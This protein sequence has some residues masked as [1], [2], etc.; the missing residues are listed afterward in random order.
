MREKWDLLF[1]S[2]EDYVALLIGQQLQLLIYEAHVENSE[3]LQEKLTLIVD[4]PGSKSA[5]AKVDIPKRSIC[6]VPVGPNVTC[7]SKKVPSNML[8]L[9]DVTPFHG[10]SLN[11]FCSPN[12]KK[13]QEDSAGDRPTQR[14]TYDFFAPF[15][16]VQHTNK[17]SDANCEFRT[18][19][20]RKE[21]N[22]PHSGE[23][24]I[25]VL[26]NAV[27]VKKGDVLRFLQSSPASKFP[28]QAKLKKFR[29]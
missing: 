12:H 27:D 13:A 10:L 1:H 5:V 28:S 24:F 22:F 26:T 20:K 17:S 7:S 21:G 2:N 18:I 11:A 15:W 16:C 9:G 3:G 19:S 4:P 23:Y 6:L 25:T 29:N 14:K 8:D